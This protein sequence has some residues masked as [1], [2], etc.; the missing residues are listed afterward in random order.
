MWHQKGRI[1]F[2]NYT[3]DIFVLNRPY[4]E[5]TISCNLVHFRQIVIFYAK[6]TWCASVISDLVI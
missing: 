5:S 1:S 6:D 3:F 4:I 2:I